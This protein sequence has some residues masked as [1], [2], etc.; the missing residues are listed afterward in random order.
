MSAEPFDRN[1]PSPGIAALLRMAWER[2]YA[3]VWDSL[4]A[5]GFEDLRDVHRPLMRYPPIEG[6]R[7]S[8]LADQLSLS[9]QAV[10]DLLRDFETMGLIR[11]ERDPAD[12]RARII[13]FT[14]RGA[15]CYATATAT[16]HSMGERWAAELGEERFNAITEGLKD[17]LMLDPAAGAKAATQR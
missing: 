14:E 3:E 10:N 4:R 5:A 11:L 17:I 9:K 16:S 7:P 1:W 2:L 15:R 12:G 6:L 8:E 13:R